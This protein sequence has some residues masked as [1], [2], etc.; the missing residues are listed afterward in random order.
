MSVSLIIKL[1]VATAD[2]LRVEQ[3]LARPL[4]DLSHQLVL[5]WVLTHYLHPMIL[6]YSLVHA[7]PHGLATFLLRA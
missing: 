5:D 3:L 6:I 7:L 4:V 1:T 2:D